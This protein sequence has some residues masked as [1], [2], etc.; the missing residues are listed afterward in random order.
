MFLNKLFRKK[1]IKIL[2]NIKELLYISIFKMS[3]SFEKIWK[4]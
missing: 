1:E 4:Q 2:K 3:Q